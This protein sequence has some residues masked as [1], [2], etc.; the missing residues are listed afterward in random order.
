MIDRILFPVDFSPSCA[1]MALFVQR[2]ATLFRSSVTLLHVCDLMSH[3]GFELYVRSPQEIAETHL[4]VAQGELESFLA[5]EFPQATCRRILRSGDAAPEIMDVARTEDIDFIVMPTHAGQFRRL[6]LGS[7]TAKVLAQA[8]C[9]VLTTKHA[10][11]IVPAPLEHRVWVCAVSLTCDSERILAFASRAAATAGAKL[12]VIHVID[13]YDPF[14][15]VEKSARRR[16]EKLFQK[17]GW[18][19]EFKIVV[20]S[21]KQA[22][23]EAARACDADL[24]VIGRTLGSGPF[25]Q[26]QSLS[27]E[28]IRDSP[29][30]VVSV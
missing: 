16:M 18:E 9:P 4:C 22:L 7:T 1:S 25:D 6:V 11:T 15:A 24:I 19:G 3:N 27:Y 30:P 12:S 14:E 29:C 28:L 17:V 26:I 8:H 2:A 13:T 23:L 5:S 21:R 10:E 20:G